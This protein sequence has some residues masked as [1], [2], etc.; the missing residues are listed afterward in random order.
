VRLVTLELTIKLLTQ[1]AVSEV[2]LCESHLAISE[3]A[4]EQNTSLLKN[5]YKVCD[6][7][8]LDQD[9]LIQIFFVSCLT[10]VFY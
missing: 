5:F 4:K 9:T 7:L 6:L 2:L 10:N 1:L 8:K 3:A